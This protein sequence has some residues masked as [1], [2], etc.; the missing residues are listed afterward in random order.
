MKFCLRFIRN[1][2]LMFFSLTILWVIVLRFVPVYFTPL[3]FIR[4]YE[5]SSEGRDVRMKH[6]WV[7]LADMPYYAPTAVIAAED[8][9]FIRHNGFDFKAIQ[10]AAKAN[11]RG[12]DLRG[13]ST[14]SQQTAKNVFLWPGRTWVRKGFE[15]YFTCLIELMWPKERIVEVYLNSVEMGE[16]IYGISAAAD[17]Y[18]GVEVK[19][20][21]RMQ[22]ATLAAIL[23]SPRRYSADNPDSYVRRRTNKIYEGMR[24]LEKNNMTLH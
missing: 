1:I 22:C 8:Q 6:S 5:Q 19:E 10:Q 18:W 9:N 17:V 12:G 24:F 13:A 4:A 23:P 2:I 16:G 14:I 15:T 7:G 21:T 11:Q 20:M 3:M